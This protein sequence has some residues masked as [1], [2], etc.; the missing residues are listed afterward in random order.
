[1]V[2]FE[3]IYTVF[4]VV[5]DK[6][7]QI[8]V[9]H[10]RDNI[11]KNISARFCATPS[12]W[13]GR[14]RRGK[15]LEEPF[16]MSFLNS[17]SCNECTIA[18]ER[19]Q[20]TQPVFPSFF[21]FFKKKKEW[22]ENISCAHMML[23]VFPTMCCDSHRSETRS[24]MSISSLEAWFL[25]SEAKLVNE[26]MSKKNPTSC[27]RQ[28]YSS[29][30]RSAAFLCS[31]KAAQSPCCMPMSGSYCGSR[32][33]Y[34]WGGH[35]VKTIERGLPAAPGEAVYYTVFVCVSIRRRGGLT[36]SLCWGGV[37][38]RLIHNDICFQIYL[39]DLSLYS[40]SPRSFF[41]ITYSYHIFVIR[42]SCNTLP[43]RRT[44]KNSRL[45]CK[46]DDVHVCIMCLRAIMNYQVS[47][48]DSCS[49]LWLTTFRSSVAPL[50]ICPSVCCSTAS[51]WSCRTPTLWMK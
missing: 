45:V 46:K 19:T 13:C 7:M 25:C 16:K 42:S 27:Y 31:Q 26:N 22:F 11:L 8:T 30:L 6:S 5:A 41:N 10:F 1:M 29:I 20:N 14:S 48:Q 37:W 34:L 40:D 23:P 9:S 43:S 2:C 17:F 21:P 32:K 36:A 28:L 12:L 3:F 4:D 51:T 49:P 47:P 38:Q 33:W 18:A 44:L 39:E 35:K 24:S 50:L 15:A